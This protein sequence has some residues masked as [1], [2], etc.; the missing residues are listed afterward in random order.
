MPNIYPIGG[1]K[2]G[3]GKTFITASLGALFAN[4]VKRLCWLIWTW[5]P[6]T[7]IDRLMLLWFRN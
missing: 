6:Q 3:V 7:S 1:I 2:R 5:E 4:R